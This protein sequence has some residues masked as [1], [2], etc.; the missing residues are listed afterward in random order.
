[1]AFHN[2]PPNG[3][4]DLPDVEELEAVEKDVATLK[5][6]TAEQGEAITALGTSI[7]GLGTSKAA[8]ADIA[9]TFSAESNYA[10]GDLV[11][12]EG[13]LYECTTEHEAAAWDAEDFTATSIDEELN[14]INSNISTLESGLTNHQAQ[15][16]LNLEVPDRKNIAGYTLDNLKSSNTEGTWNNNVYT[17]NDVSFTCDISNGFVTSITADSNGQTVQSQANLR[18]F[19]PG[20]MPNIF[21]GMLLNGCNSNN[22]R[23]FIGAFYSN[24]GTS[25]AGEKAQFDGTDAVI[26]NNYPYIRFGITIN[27]GVIVN[28]VTFYPMIRPATITDPTFAPYIPSVETRL[29]AVES[30]V[31]VSRLQASPDTNGYI[32]LSALGF[33]KTS[34]TYV[35]AIATG[36]S[37]TASYDLRAWLSDN[38]GWIITVYQTGTFNKVTDTTATVDFIVIGVNA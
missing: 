22:D 4:P 34:F 3:F 36:A 13:V 31:K 17:V 19:A 25:W 23:I 24:N 29:E 38:Y 18:L 27:D 8:K 1:M 33:A 10:V 7:T 32:N 9:P 16:D 12:Y 11:Y 14:A 30:R 15:N 2:V 20:Y 26:S 37:T 35:N 6:T 21:G 5:T 28:N